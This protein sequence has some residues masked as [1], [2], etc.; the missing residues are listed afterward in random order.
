MN[1]PIPCGQAR[2]PG[3]AFNPGL[4]LHPAASVHL[5]PKRTTVARKE[6]LQKQKHQTENSNLHDSPSI[7]PRDEAS[8]DEDS[9]IGESDRPEPPSDKPEA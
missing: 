6:K 7:P 4:T 5:L 2:T 9:V 1:M 8:L 3:T